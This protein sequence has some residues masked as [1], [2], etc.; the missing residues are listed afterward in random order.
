MN[1]CCLRPVDGARPRVQH[2]AL[3]SIQTDDCSLHVKHISA[4]TGAFFTVDSYQPLSLIPQEQLVTR[5][6]FR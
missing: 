1:I 5:V 2:T 4:Q 6:K 3:C